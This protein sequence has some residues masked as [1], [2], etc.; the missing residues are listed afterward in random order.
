MSRDEYD[1]FTRGEL[2][3]LVHHNPDWFDSDPAQCINCDKQAVPYVYDGVM[4]PTPDGHARL[5]LDEPSCLVCRVDAAENMHRR[6][7]QQR[8][9]A[10]F[11]GSD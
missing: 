6:G 4:I 5:R 10:A 7:L 11:G 9:L 3:T 1:E 2:A 8:G